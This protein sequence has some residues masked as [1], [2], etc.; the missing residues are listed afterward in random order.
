MIHAHVFVDG[1]YTE[2]LW[3]SEFCCKPMIGETISSKQGTM[4]KIRTIVH[5]MG[6]PYS[7]KENLQPMLQ[8]WLGD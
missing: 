8:I 7:D 1:K 4:L 3:P 5:K 2:E 6:F